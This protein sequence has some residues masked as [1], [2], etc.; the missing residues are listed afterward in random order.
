MVGE[1]LLVFDREIIRGVAGDE[2]VVVDFLVS[3]LRASLVSHCEAVDELHSGLLGVTSSVL[4]YHKSH[5]S[6]TAVNRS[7]L[8]DHE[9]DELGNTIEGY[10]S[11]PGT[12]ASVYR[13]A[14]FRGRAISG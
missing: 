6:H 13:N 1:S 9:E 4:K 12:W 11:K 10:G 5:K 7:I 3:H 14:S 8:V 2:G